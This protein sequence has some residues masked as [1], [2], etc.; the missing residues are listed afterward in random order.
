MLFSSG[1]LMVH[2]LNGSSH[3][4]HFSCLY[5]LRLY[6][7]KDHTPVPDNH[8]YQMCSSPGSKSVCTPGVKHDEWISVP[9]S[10][11]SEKT[12]QKWNIVIMMPMMFHILLS[13]NDD[14]HEDMVI[15]HE[16][17][18]MRSLMMVPHM[19]I[20]KRRTRVQNF[21]LLFS[22]CSFRSN[23]HHLFFFLTMMLLNSFWSDALMIG[24]ILLKLLQSMSVCLL[25]WMY[26]GSD[27]RR[28][29]WPS[30]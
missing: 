29:L 28:Q 18:V 1:Q 2:S 9:P 11:L 26:Q 4:A 12:H 10:M 22:F 16:W 27:T 25:V 23:H 15:S 14:H 13:S 3:H 6:H 21:L 17:G 8:D 24:V 30:G 7:P 5:Q 19:I 20:K